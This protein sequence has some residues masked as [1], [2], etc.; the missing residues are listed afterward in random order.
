MATTSIVTTIKFLEDSQCAK[1]RLLCVN[2]EYS[3]LD[4]IY[5]GAEAPAFLLVFPTAIPD[6]LEFTE[7]CFVSIENT[8]SSLVVGAKIVARRGDTTLELVATEII[9]P[10]SLR[11]YFRVFYQT[12]IIA[13]QKVLGRNVANDPVKLEGTTVDLSASGVLAIFP[14]KFDYRDRVFLEFN[15]IGTSRSIQCLSHVVRV[16]HIRKSRCQVALHFDHI[17]AEDREA[18][19]AEC[20]R[21]QRKQLRQRMQVE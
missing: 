2:G 8:S 15:L 9:D 1:V 17:P 10:A 7:T 11:E 16:H 3:Y 14:Q 21:E 12:P 19:I 4:C 18:I 5:M 13:T 6:N 20:M